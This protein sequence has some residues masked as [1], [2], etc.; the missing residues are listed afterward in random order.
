M[1]EPT[2]LPVDDMHFA[3]SPGERASGLWIRLRAHLSVL[4]EVERRRNDNN[5]DPQET[6][7]VRGRIAMLKKMIDFGNDPPPVTTV[8][9]E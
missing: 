8:D 1:R 5:L 6:A 3:L 2:T 7:M 4:L 9:H